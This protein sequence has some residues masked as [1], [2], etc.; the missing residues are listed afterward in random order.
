ML[1]A[2]PIIKICFFCA[3]LL[4]FT[5]ETSSE[6]AYHPDYPEYHQDIIDMTD[7]MDNRLGLY[8]RSKLL[9]CGNYLTARLMAVCKSNYNSN[10]RGAPDSGIF[11]M[12]FLFYFIRKNYLCFHSSTDEYAYGESAS[13]IAEVDPIHFPYIPRHAALSMK[14]L[15]MRKKRASIGIVDECCKKSCTNQEIMG[16]CG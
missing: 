4:S 3:Y 15:N 6:H 7:I 14:Q 9:T 16:Y 11:S 8:K 12:N 5:K 10:K 1:T 13:H 2:L